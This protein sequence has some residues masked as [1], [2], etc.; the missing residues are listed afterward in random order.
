M[1]CGLRQ[2]L[3]TKVSIKKLKKSELLIIIQIIIFK[4]SRHQSQCRRS[5]ILAQLKL[6]RS[7]EKKL[8]DARA[9]VMEYFTREY[10]YDENGTLTS[11]NLVEDV[12]RSLCL[13]LVAATIQTQ[14]TPAFVSM[15]VTSKIDQETIS[16][17]EQ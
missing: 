5:M 11:E 16:I 15:L 10:R 3:K 2:S 7:S 17:F 1:L 8:L 4:L 12:N 14:M 13:K 6:D 9:N